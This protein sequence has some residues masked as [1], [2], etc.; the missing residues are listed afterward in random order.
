MEDKEYIA[1]GKAFETLL[2]SGRV[3]MVGSAC[4]G[5]SGYQHMGL[6]FWTDHQEV[7]GIEEYNEN[8]KSRIFRYI[9]GQV[10]VPT[11][12]M[13]LPSLM[14]LIGVFSTN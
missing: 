7:P 8:S 9:L 10:D 2:S 6:E 13:D 14:D 4:L 5:E 11:S 3:R 12:E 1:L